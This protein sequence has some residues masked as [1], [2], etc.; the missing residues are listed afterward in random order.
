[1]MI[2]IRCVCVDRWRVDDAIGGG[3]SQCR[4]QVLRGIRG[5]LIGVEICA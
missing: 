5:R 3:D 1:M 4:W 2:M